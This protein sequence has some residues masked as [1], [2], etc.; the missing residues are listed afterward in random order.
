MVKYKIWHTP[1]KDSIDGKD[2]YRVLHLATKKDQIMG[3]TWL[4]AI[5]KSFSTKEEAQKALEEVKHGQ[6]YR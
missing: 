4:D 2:H 3:E 5:G 6:V 1:A